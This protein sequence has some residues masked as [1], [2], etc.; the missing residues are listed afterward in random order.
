[1]VEQKGEGQEVE[2]VREEEGG[3]EGEREE[4]EEGERKD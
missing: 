4:R 1:V 2:A 3:E